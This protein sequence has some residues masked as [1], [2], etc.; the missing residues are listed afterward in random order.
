MK[1]QAVRRSALF[2]RLRAWVRGLDIADRADAL[3]FGPLVIGGVAANCYLL[4]VQG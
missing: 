1:P 4:L 2:F 3:F